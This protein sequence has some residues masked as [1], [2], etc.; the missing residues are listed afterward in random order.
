V[1]IDQGS[2]E[3]V[4]RTQVEQR[5]AMESNWSGPDML[6]GPLTLPLELKRRLNGIFHFSALT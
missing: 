1:P 2:R 4:K 5:C 6:N 3:Q